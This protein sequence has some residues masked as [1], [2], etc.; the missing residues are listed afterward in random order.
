MSAD[1]FERI[2]SCKNCRFVENDK[3]SGG[4]KLLLSFLSYIVS[5]YVFVYNHSVF[6]YLY[7]YYIISLRMLKHIVN[8]CI[9]EKT[10][11]V[12]K[13]CVYLL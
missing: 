6:I 4:Q 5:T 10:S 3:F 8:N 13:T 12:G 11:L 9:Q 2:T 1:N 7:V